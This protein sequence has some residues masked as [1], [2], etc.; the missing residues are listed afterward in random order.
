MQSVWQEDFLD[1][2]VPTTR[3][4]LARDKSSIFSHE[5]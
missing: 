4:D 2:K 1:L 5:Y 3:R